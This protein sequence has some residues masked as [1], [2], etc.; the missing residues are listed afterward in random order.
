M[1]KTLNAFTAFFLFTLVLFGASNAA[2]ALSCAQPKVDSEMISTTDVIFEGVVT[3]EKRMVG[4][5]EEDVTV[6]LDKTASFTFQVT[7]SWKGVQK[8][9]VLTIGRNTY[10]GDGFQMGQPYLVFASRSAKDNGLT[11]ELCGPTVPLQY[12][13]AYK[14][15]LKSYFAGQAQPPLPPHAE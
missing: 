1:Q 4:G 7:R 8:G 14:Q 15:A 13:G 2:Q 5:E 6:K 12:A 9:D 11:A 3:G 10:W